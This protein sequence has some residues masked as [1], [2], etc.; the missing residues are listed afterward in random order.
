MNQSLDDFIHKNF[1]NRRRDRG[2]SRSRGPRR[3]SVSGRNPNASVSGRRRPMQ[4]APIADAR[5]LIIQKKRQKLTD[6]R[7]Q[8][9]QLAR[10]SDLRSKLDR[11]R[12]G[13][14]K[15]IVRSRGYLGITKQTALNGEISLK[16]NKQQRFPYFAPKDRSAVRGPLRRIVKND[17]QDVFISGGTWQ[18]TAPVIRRTVVNDPFVPPDMSLA[19]FGSS[20]QP[21][22]RTIRNDSF[23]PR[24]TA[25]FLSDDLAH[26]SIKRT[27]ND[28]P[29][30]VSMP[31]QSRYGWDSHALSRRRGNEL[32]VQEPSSMMP[33]RLLSQREDWGRQNVPKRRQEMVI[34]SVTIEDSD[35][36]DDMGLNGMVGSSRVGSEL[37]ARLDSSSGY[38]GRPSALSA[39]PKPPSHP[40]AKPG[41]R[42][43]VSNL[44][45]TVIHED[46]RELFEDV[47]TLL[48]S[49][50]VRPGT[51]EVVYQN[52]DDAVKAVD[53][54]HNR[55]LD[56]QPMKCL[57]VNS[58]APKSS[59]S[60]RADSM[61]QFKLLAGTKSSIVPD[62][63][64]I[65]KALFNKS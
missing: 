65:H 17:M 34:P 25:V 16:T 43:V 48:D 45:P 18:K 57:L 2:R 28:I 64:T 14:R 35:S 8:L 15:D 36:D 26:P 22:H 6:A 12:G 30:Q 41:H 37:K 59:S 31:S 27:L 42:I 60:M 20:Y 7:D 50:L 63:M 38:S 49:R 53:L 3:S 10:H 61:S 11:I 39:A 23:V 55:H 29:Y 40:A 24:G 5:F 44:H 52:L 4:S 33:A 62:V 54:Y 1:S 9:A 32:I 56:G 51:A 58:S 47:G 21:V 19:G 46:I 13:T